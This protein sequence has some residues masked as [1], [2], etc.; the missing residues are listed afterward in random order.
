M[1]AKHKNKVYGL[2]LLLIGGVGGNADRIPSFVS[3]LLEPTT[4]RIEVLEEK[5][6]N[7]EAQVDKLTS[8]EETLESSSNVPR[9]PI[10]K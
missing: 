5:V 9:I 7:L 4:D 3:Y 10:L 6:E 2:I 1:W 8:G